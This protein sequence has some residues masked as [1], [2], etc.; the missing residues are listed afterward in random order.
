M[1]TNKKV[2]TVTGDA[3]GLAFLDAAN[4]ML[5]K[6]AWYL[7]MGSNP[8]AEQAINLGVITGKL[9]LEIKTIKRYVA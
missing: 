4:V 3:M 1:G 8:T 6:A 7:S 9:E 5:E 2:S